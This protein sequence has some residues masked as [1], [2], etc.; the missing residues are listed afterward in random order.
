MCNEIP[1]RQKKIDET[2]ALLTL[3]LDSSS[4]AIGHNSLGKLRFEN[5]V[6]QYE[7]VTP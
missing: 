4:A 2:T 3:R 7:T 5:S 6:W 1:L